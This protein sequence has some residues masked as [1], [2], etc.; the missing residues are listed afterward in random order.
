M[1]FRKYF[2]LLFAYTRLVEAYIE[3]RKL[4]ESWREAGRIL[5]QFTAK[6]C[7]KDLQVQLDEIRK[8]WEVE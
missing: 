7:A 4:P 3:L 1:I 2:K 6:D 8:E 5:P